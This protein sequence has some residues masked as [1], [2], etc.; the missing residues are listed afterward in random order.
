MSMLRTT[1]AP[2]LALGLVLATTATAQARDLCL[3]LDS[4]LG[5]SIVVG[6]GFA[7]PG[8]N[9]CKPFNGFTSTTNNFYVVA[10]TG[11][12]SADGFTLNLHF[13][14]QRASGG[15][16]V[17][18]ICGFNAPTGN[19]GCSGWIANPGSQPELLEYAGRTATVQPCTVD[20][21]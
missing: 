17:S 8:K 9:R 1:R 20:V 21:P 18:A 7:A 3:T 13:T 14:A 12:T 5:S 10:G 2:I 6:K 16:S 4:I 11:C 19:G 15:V